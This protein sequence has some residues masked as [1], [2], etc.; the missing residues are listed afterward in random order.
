MVDAMAS[1]DFVQHG[2]EKHER[3]ESKTTVL[4]N[5][6]AARDPI[7]VDQ[8]IYVTLFQTDGLC[9][10]LVARLISHFVRDT[11]EIEVRYLAQPHSI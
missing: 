8:D 7:W 9:G 5:G 1:G 4:M 2:G 6:H 11:Q 10:V 3:I